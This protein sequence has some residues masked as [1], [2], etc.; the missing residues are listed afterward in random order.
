MAGVVAGNFGAVVVS[1][2]IYQYFD[3]KLFI[4]TRTL[5]LALHGKHNPTTKYT[6]KHTC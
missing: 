2:A 5:G 1:R 6:A 3:A 4:Q